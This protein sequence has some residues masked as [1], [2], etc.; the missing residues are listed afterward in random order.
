MK[1]CSVCSKEVEMKNKPFSVIGVRII[2][3]IDG[4]LS[5][6]EVEFL[7]KQ[8]GVYDINKEYNICYECW[9]RSLGVKPDSE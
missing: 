4:S 7:N 6:E 9:L 5:K 8:F 3:V 2:T 1:N